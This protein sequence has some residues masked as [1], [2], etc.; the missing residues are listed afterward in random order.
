MQRSLTED[1]QIVRECPFCGSD[2]RLSADGLSGSTGMD[3]VVH[4]LC[5]C[6]IFEMPESALGR[7]LASV[8]AT[9]EADP[10]DEGVDP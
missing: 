3:R 9:T 10:A 6:Y 5:G 4:A 7:L 8:L 1:V 2:V